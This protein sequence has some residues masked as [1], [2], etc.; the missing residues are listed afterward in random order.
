MAAIYILA[1]C[2]GMVVG[3]PKGSPSEV[4]DVDYLMPEVQ[5]KVVSVIL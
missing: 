1:L 5:P 2:V 3:A 4:K